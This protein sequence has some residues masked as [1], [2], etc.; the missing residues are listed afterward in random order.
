MWSK[1]FSKDMLEIYSIFMVV[2]IAYGIYGF[3]SF[4]VHWLK[5]NALI[6]FI[7]FKNVFYVTI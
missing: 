6:F 4:V 1:E 2:G 3:Y 7:Y 5:K